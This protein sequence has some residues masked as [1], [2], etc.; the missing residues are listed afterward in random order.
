LTGGLPTRPRWLVT[1]GCW[2]TGKG[3][4]YVSD[5]ADLDV[6]RIGAGQ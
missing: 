4:R 3:G 5:L 2:L 6:V 1:D